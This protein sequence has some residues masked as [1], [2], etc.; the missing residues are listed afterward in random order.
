M[1]RPAKPAATIQRA[2]KLRREMSAAEVKLWCELRLRPGNLKFRHQ[3]PAGPYSL[4][5]YCAAARLVIEV[6][7]EVHG[8]G[9]QPI[10]DLARDAFLARYGL[11]TLRIPAAELNRN[12]DGVIAWIIA[13]ASARTPL[14]HRP[15]RAG[16]PPPQAKLGED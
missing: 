12:M 13:T 3:H 15:K 5:F 8:R 1:R 11:E 10:R 4:D 2:R 9:D 7:G 6:D 14:H 16:G